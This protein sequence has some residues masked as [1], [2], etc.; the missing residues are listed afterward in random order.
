MSSPASSPSDPCNA[1]ELA[2]GLAELLRDRRGTEDAAAADLARLLSHSLALSSIG[3]ERNARLGLL[4]AI[5]SE[6]TGEFVTSKRYDRARAE[7]AKAGESWPTA[8]ALSRAYGHWLDAVEAGCR[9]W[10]HGGSARVPHSYAHARAAKRGYKPK[11]IVETIRRCRVDLGL[12]DGGRS[13]TGRADQAEAERGWPSQWEY[14][15]WA[16]VSRRLGQRAGVEVRIPGALQIRNAFG[17][18]EEAVQAA[19]RVNPRP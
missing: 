3:A 16:I 2:Q 9:F 8:S 6:G 18:Y 10:F 7:W 5:I 12:A 1:T 14:R 15:A 4:V 17:G 13:L 19:R 11:E